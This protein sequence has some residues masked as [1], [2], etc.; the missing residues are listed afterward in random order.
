VNKLSFLKRFR[1]T[2]NYQLLSPQELKLYIVLLISTDEIGVKGT[3]DMR[4]LRKAIGE[5]ITIDKLNEMASNLER[6]GL[7][8]IVITEDGK[9]MHFILNEI[10]NG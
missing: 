1:D 4:L 2:K 5:R 6:Y 8:E 7:A 9:Q 3:I 10:E